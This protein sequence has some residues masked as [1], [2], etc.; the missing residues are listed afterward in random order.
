MSR[1]L[2]ALPLVAISSVARAEAAADG[3]SD[4]QVDRISTPV[5]G[6]TPVP[7]GKWPD[8]VAVL[9]AQG[10][11]T[12]TLIAPDVVLT[13]GHCAG[14]HPTQ[15]IADTT[16]Y[17]AAG[18]VKVGVE[19]ITAHPAWK[20]TFDV[21][22]VVLAT[23]ITGVTPRAVGTGCTFEGFSTDKRVRLVGFG[24]TD[25]AG[26]GNNTALHEAVAPVLDPDCSDGNG[27]AI[28][29]SPAG[30]FVAGGD[31]T[32]SCFGDSGGPVYLETPRGSVVIGAVSRGLDGAALPCGGGGIYVRTDKILA[33]IEATSGR[34]ISRDSCDDG[35][36]DGIE[37]RGEVTGGCQA[38]GG[39]AGLL[40][41][42]A[43]LGARRRRR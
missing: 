30:E 6:G 32:D 5:V 15:V 14:I 10:S 39:D 35:L 22:V 40:V 27:C 19:R 2:I 20:N 3:A 24:L 4:P 31:G 18:G 38:G 16:N 37:E 21:S 36:G 9:G 7:A 43:M 42:A 41:V 1:L 8:A 11:C 25:M 26:K 17:R 23:P 28:G 33:W 34:P 12:G 29:A 13:A